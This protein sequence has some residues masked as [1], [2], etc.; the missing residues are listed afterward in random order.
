M[1]CSFF[2]K[3]VVDLFDV[4]PD[5]KM[6]TD[7][8]NHL[9]GCNACARYYEVVF[10]TMADLK[11]RVGIRA[12][13]E[14]KHNILG[15]VSVTPR[16]GENAR[17]RVI[18]MFSHAAWPRIAAVAA[19]LVICITLI[20]LMLNPGLVYADVRAANRLIGESLKSLAGLQSVYMLIRVRTTP[21][22]N[23]ESISTEGEFVNNALWK[24]FSSPARWRMEKPGRIV[25]MDGRNQYLYR[26]GEEFAMKAG[27]DAGLVESL[28]LFLD[29]GRILETEQKRAL[30][31]KAFCHV[32]QHDSTLVLT[33]TSKAAGDFTNPYLLNKSIAGSNN[34]RVYVFDKQSKRLISFRVS[35]QSGHRE[36]PVIQSAVIRYDQQIPDSIFRISLPPGISFMELDDYYSHG[37]SDLPVAS[38]EEATRIIF[39][40]FGR[41]EWNTVKK[42][43]PELRFQ[44]GRVASEIRQYYGGLRV[45]SIGKSFRSGSYPGVFVPYR[46]KLKSGEVISHNLAIRNDNPRR[47][48]VV[49][50]GL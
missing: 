12:G 16:I 49:D 45:I 11:P 27:A 43:I 24:I 34:R 33:V 26:P 25:V 21:G 18:R 19:M 5:Q 29:P 8:L 37:G 42:F 44:G 1:D 32:E 47:L 38:G 13:E 31:N 9:E 14:L 22:D 28:K 48:W 3:N 36:I 7:L 6:Q 30:Q 35:V 40:S 2:L 4:T 17:S 20:P 39:E 46:I 15:Q 50:G 41:E 23:F 10:D